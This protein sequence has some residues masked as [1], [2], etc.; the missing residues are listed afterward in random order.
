EPRHVVPGRVERVQ[1]R[2]DHFSRRDVAGRSS[3]ALTQRPAG[4]LPRAAV[5]R[6]RRGAE[7][8]RAGGE[9]RQDV[10]DGGDVMAFFWQNPAKSLQPNPRTLYR[11]YDKVTEW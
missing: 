6:D 8:R 1:A 10:D 9:L 11:A 4:R 7:A 2:G 5:P 3:R